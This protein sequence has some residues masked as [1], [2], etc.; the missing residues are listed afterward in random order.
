[1]SADDPK[2]SVLLPVHNGS[3]HLRAAVESVLEQT[4]SDFELLIVDDCSSDDSVSIVEGYPDPRIRLVRNERN[5]GQVETLNRGLAAARGQY[6]ARM[7]Q[8]D[9][10]LPARFERQVA[11]LDAEPQVGVVA[12][13]MDFVD[14]S[15]RV[16]WK[17][18]D[19]VD[20][21]CAFVYLILV[22]RLPLAHPTVMFRRRLVLELGGYDPSVHLAEDQD[23]WRRIAL[24]HQEAR[25]VKEVLFRYRVHEGQQSQQR[26]AEQNENNLEA[27]ERFVAAVSARMPAR[28]T[29][30]LLTGDETFWRECSSRADAQRLA[31]SLERFLADAQ[32]TLRLSPEQHARLERMLRAR[33]RT[34][35]RRSWRV[36]L[37]ALWRTS[38]PLHAFGTAGLPPR[39]ASSARAAYALVVLTGPFLRP[40]AR[41]KRAAKA[42]LWSR[43]WFKGLRRRVRH[44]RWIRAAYQAHWS[45]SR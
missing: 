38:P 16:L 35:A 20:D 26:L 15:G 30:L 14:P 10:C 5:L 45:R 27:L 36:G 42:A 44:W 2:V 34:L 43:A 19:V 12:S 23:L 11:L 32:S 4:F 22:N 37:G 25:V 29:R 39:A 28:L 9:V 40:L 8:D 17:L 1:M 18:R 21:Y 7:D 13:W 31:A 3:E 24:A 6:V 41:A 33:V